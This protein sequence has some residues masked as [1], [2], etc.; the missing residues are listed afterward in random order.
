[1]I[2]YYELHTK[3]TTI[4]TPLT[5]FGPPLLIFLWITWIVIDGLKKS[6]LYLAFNM[7]NNID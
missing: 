6:I 3:M 1:M 7:E 4:N 5:Y 2:R